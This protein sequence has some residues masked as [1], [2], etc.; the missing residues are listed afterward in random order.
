M[1]SQ[2]IVGSPKLRPKKL[3]LQK[4]N[5]A[6]LPK[7]SDMHIEFK[8]RRKEDHL[9]IRKRISDKVDNDIGIHGSA[10]WERRMKRIN[11]KDWRAG[12]IQS[13]KKREI[14]N[15]TMKQREGKTIVRIFD[16]L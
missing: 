4:S 14:G 12:N 2:L 8:K 9:K 5:L 3:Q 7:T 13:D 11:G 6:S 16:H 10:K 1:K 15:P